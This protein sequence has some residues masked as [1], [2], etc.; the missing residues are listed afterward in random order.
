MSLGKEPSGSDCSPSLA[1]GSRHWGHFLLDCPWTTPPSEP[2]T[3]TQ[4]HLARSHQAFPHGS[5]SC[6]GGFATAHSQPSQLSRQI[7][8]RPGPQIK[9][10]FMQ[11]GER[12]RWEGEKKSTTANLTKLAS[13]KFLSVRLGAGGELGAR[14]NSEGAFLTHTIP[15]KSEHMYNS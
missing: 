4:Q 11:K 2:R 1:H 6:N 5:T 12:S 8:Q 3:H 9:H 15:S 13:N 10:L 7:K 14:I